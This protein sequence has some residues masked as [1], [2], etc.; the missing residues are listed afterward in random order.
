VSVE[1]LPW[2]V[3]FVAPSARQTDE[4][5]F[6]LRAVGIEFVVTQLD[7]AWQLSVPQ[8]SATRASEELAAYR[9]EYRA[10]RARPTGQL[11]ELE[12]G[13]IGVA[14]FV[15]VLLLAAVAANQDYFGQDWLARGR[16]DVDRVRA[17]EWWRTVTALCLHA[18]TVHLAGN[19][20]FGGFF[21]LY[22]GRYVGSGIAWCGI[23]LG[24]TLGNALNALVQPPGHLAIGASTAT[25]AALGLLAAYTWRRGAHGGAGWRT[26]AAPLT[27]ALGLLAFTGTGGGTG[28]GDVDIIAH[29]TGFVVGLGLGALLA[30]RALPR[31]PMAQLGAGSAAA[32][33]LAGAWIWGFAAA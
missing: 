31:T 14:V 30:A 6:V 8:A 16:L 7:G 17:G 32:A 29:L 5:G 25:F 22:I 1:H 20:A 23:L 19:V 10:P 11:D 15:A 33:V 24:G 4:A 9:A 13:W 27:A 2:V 12:N 3:V 21:G 28:G 18:D 26:R